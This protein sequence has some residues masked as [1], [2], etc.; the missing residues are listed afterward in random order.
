MGPAIWL[1]LGTIGAVIAYQKAPPP[2]DNSERIKF[3]LLIPL[4]LLF[5]ALLGP[6]GLLMFAFTP[7]LKIYT[8]C[9]TRIRRNASVC[10]ACGRDVL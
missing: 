4:M 2:R 1:L 9:K 5:T 3:T 7:A 10:R 6:I 8:S